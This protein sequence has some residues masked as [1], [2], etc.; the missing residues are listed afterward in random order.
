MIPWYKNRD[1]LTWIVL[2]LAAIFTYLASMPSL[3]DWTYAQ[4]MQTC[5]A[6]AFGLAGY[7]KSSPLKGNSDA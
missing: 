5:A 3:L 2:G 6:G 1:S 4:W 7:L